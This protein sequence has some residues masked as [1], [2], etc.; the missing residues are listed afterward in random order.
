MGGIACDSAKEGRKLLA[1]GL[2]ACRPGRVGECSHLPLQTLRLKVSQVNLPEDLGTRVPI[3]KRKL[4]AREDKA[5]K[6]HNK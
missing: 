3:P 4:S 2:A 6:D 1:A 5:V